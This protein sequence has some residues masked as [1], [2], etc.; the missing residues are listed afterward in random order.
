M[1][2]AVYINQKN[3]S[4]RPYKGNSIISL[5]NKYVVL[6]IKSTGYSYEYDSILNV[7]ALKINEGEIIDK[8]ESL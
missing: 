2:T 1:E 5:P 6:D 4:S 3:K 7:C 8:F